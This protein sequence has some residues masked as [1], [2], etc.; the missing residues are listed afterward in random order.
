[1]PAC[2][3]CKRWGRELEREK[4]I[5]PHSIRR[6]K[7]APPPFPV[8]ITPYPVTDVP[9]STPRILTMGTSLGHRRQCV[10]V[11]VEVG[12]DPGDVVHLLQR[13]EQIKQALGVG[14][15]DLHRALGKERDLG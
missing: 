10:G 3:S 5:T 11:D 6:P 4:R 14:A 9:G 8:S 13:L 2:S 15:L 1:M 12:V 7:P